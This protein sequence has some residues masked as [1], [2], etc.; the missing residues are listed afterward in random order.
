MTFRGG[1]L[2]GYALPPGTVWL[3]TEIAEARGRQDLYVRQTP[4]LLEALRQTALIQSAESSNRIEGISVSPARLRPLVLSDVPPRDRSEEEVQNYR[5]ALDLIHKSAGDLELS[6]ATCLRLH[7]IIQEG[8]GDAGQLKRID[9]EIVEVRPGRPPVVRFRAV[10]AAATPAGIEELVRSYRHAIDQERVHPLVAVAGAVLDF[11]CIHPFRDGNGRVSRLLT[12]LLLYHHGY[13]VGRYISLE[14]LVEDAKEDYYEALRRSS[15]RWH[16]GDHDLLPWLDHFLSI[17]RRAFRDFGQRADR[18]LAGRGAK[19][20]LLR[21]A[22]ESFPAEFTAADLH[23]SVPGVSL[24][25]VRRVLAQEQRARR[26]RC[27]VRGREA[28]WKRLAP[29]TT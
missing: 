3:L 13:E 23:R 16:D 29:R 10:G 21:A 24:D 28:R 11:L 5:K 12:L 4:Q 17:L 22:I 19:T 14:R 25:M 7:G 27:V 6:A 18:L 9:N 15:Q 8:A 1:R 2:G 20:A 26:L